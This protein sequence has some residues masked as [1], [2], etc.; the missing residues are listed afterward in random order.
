MMW[1]L[2][3]YLFGW[4]YVAYTTFSG[5]QMLSRVRFTPNKTPYIFVYG[6]IR[7]LGPQK[8]RWV[9]LT[10]DKEVF[11]ANATESTKETLTARAA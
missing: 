1:K 6:E 4:H 7:F 3:H 11:L 9:A 2:W 8:D 10:F 5:D